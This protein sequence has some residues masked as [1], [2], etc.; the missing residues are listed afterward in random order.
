[1]PSDQ[2]LKQCLKRQKK[3]VLGNKPA[4]IEEIKIPHYLEVTKNKEK[5]CIVEEWH[6]INNK[7]KHFKI[8]L[9]RTNLLLLKD[10]PFWVMDGTFSSSPDLFKQ[11][12]SIHG[13]VGYEINSRILPLVYILMT[14]KSKELYK[15][16][17]MSLNN[18]SCSE[19]HP[20]TPSIIMSDF[21]LGA[22][23]ASKEVFPNVKNKT[24]WFHLNQSIIR[25]IN[26]SALKKEH[27][28]NHKLQKKCRM[29]VALAFLPPDEI[30]P[31]FIELSSSFP[32][33]GLPIIKYFDENY[34]RGKET[35]T[36]SSTSYSGPRF[37]PKIWSVYENNLEGL[38]RTSNNV[39]S[40]HNRFS[41]LI[42]RKHPHIV[43]FIHH[44]YD[45]NNSVEALC[46]QIRWRNLKR[47]PLCLAAQKSK[48][49][50]QEVIEKKN[51]IPVM[52]FLDGIASN[53][54]SRKV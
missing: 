31:A 34:V 47:I 38:P 6:N 39:E 4:T 12:Y 41:N 29:L 36:R 9:S 40:W 7:R 3:M 21:E 24:C 44:L 19:G 45:K 14:S 33:V 22:I 16:M 1:L 37:N 15:H 43:F 18:Y 32:N 5:F 8:F 13:Q 26:K 20:L 46:I 51:S 30:I 10:S 48:N 49:R 54:Y 28:I 23:T 35:I 50:M 11:V 25:F 53:Y 42:G 17:F 27:S 2:A 52:E